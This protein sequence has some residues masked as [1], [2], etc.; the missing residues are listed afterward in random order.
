MLGILTTLKTLQSVEIFF[1][2]H[3]STQDPTVDHYGGSMEEEDGIK[4]LFLRYKQSLK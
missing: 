3:A 1:L 4:T 2:S